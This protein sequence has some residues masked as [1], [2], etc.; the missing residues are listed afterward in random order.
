MHCISMHCNALS[1][2]MD[3]NALKENEL[4]WIFLIMHDNAIKENEFET[5]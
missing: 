3:Y 2:I 5:I 1:K 4:K